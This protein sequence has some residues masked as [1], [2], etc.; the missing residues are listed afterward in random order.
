MPTITLEEHYAI[1]AFLE[2][3]GRELKE[4]ATSFGGP[5]ARILEQLC[6][7]GDKMEY[8]F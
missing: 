8:N 6:D 3:P 2:G 7:L 5:A 1:P 4:Q